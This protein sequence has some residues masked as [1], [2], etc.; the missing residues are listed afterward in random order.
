MSCKR[1]LRRACP[2]GLIAALAASAPAMASP[3]SSCALLNKTLVK[4][5]FG[6]KY[7]E[8]APGFNGVADGATKQECDGIVTAINPSTKKERTFI[9][10]HGQKL[11]A[12]GKVATLHVETWETIGDPGDPFDPDKVLTD[13]ETASDGFFINYL[14]GTSFAVP[15][16]GASVGV[17]YQ[18]PKGGVRE[19]SAMWR[20]TGGS[21]I[22]LTIV[23]KRSLPIESRLKKLAAN[24]VSAFTS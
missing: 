15:K 17:G 20:T 21:V 10:T 3:N 14:H 6:L 19:A 18:G 24:T 13:F 2:I 22:Q 16:F 11:T 7:F 4:K 8:T 5:V 1:V 23:Q 12:A 9:K